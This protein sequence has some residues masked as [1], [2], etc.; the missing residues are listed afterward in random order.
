MTQQQIADHLG[1]DRSN[2]SKWLKSRDI[3]S[4]YDLD[5]IRIRYIREL[6]EK[7][8]GRF[9]SGDLDPL[10]ERARKDKAMADRYE[11]ENAVA[12]GLLAN[13]EEI[14]DFVSENNRRAKVRLLKLPR[15]LAIAVPRE[16]ATIV[17]AESKAV[18]REAL[19][20]LANAI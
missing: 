7:A 20:E 18:I 5:K 1:V 10:Q 12:D 13:R 14:E 17:E 2:I 8:G 16:V 19:E 15:D 6:A 3:K 9:T 11:R 4:P